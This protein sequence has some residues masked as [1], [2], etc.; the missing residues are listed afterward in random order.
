MAKKQKQEPIKHEVSRILL[1]RDGKPS[2][3][4][5]LAVTFSHK[6]GHRFTYYDHV[7]GVQKTVPLEGCS[8]SWA[9]EG[10][11][12]ASAMAEDPA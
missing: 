3:I 1:S 12:E 7:D 11:A 5:P 9:A 8:F 4:T 10:P 2:E 6:D